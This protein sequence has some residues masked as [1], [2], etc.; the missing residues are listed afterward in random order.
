MQ[1]LNKNNEVKV[2]IITGAGKA[3][4]AGAD[5][6]TLYDERETNPLK[7]SLT[8]QIVFRAIEKSKKPV[9]TAINGYA[10]GGGNEL[11]LSADYRIVS[12]LN[13]KP[14]LGQLEI[15]LGLIPGN[16]GTRRLTDIVGPR[17][18][19]ILMLSGARI[20]AKYAAAIGMIDEIAPDALIRARQLARQ[21][22]EDM[23]NPLNSKRNFKLELR[24]RNK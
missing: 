21:I 18:A 5:V 6:Q 12:R 24:K 17:M 14:I 9:I 19:A 20:N 11:A 8:G 22:I 16:G 7:S 2:I 23:A 15:T 13:D 10:F 4:M 1:E 3:F